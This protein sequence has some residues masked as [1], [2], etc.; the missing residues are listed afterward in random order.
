MT[1]RDICRACAERLCLSVISEHEDAGKSA[2]TTRGR[3]ALAAAMAVAIGSRAAIIVYRF[4]RL[5]RNLG[6]SYAIRDA[7]MAKG[8]RIIS[9][10][11]G[12]AESSPFSRAMFAMMATFAELENDI[13]RER[14][15]LGKTARAKQGG[16]AGGGSPVGFQNGRN[17][18]GIPILI[19]D[20]AMSEIIRAAF[21]DFIGGAI[22][23]A[24]MIQ[25]LCNAGIAKKTARRAILAPVYGGIIRNAWTGGQDIP[26]AFSGLIP[27]DQWRAMQSK[28]SRGKR[29]AL[30]DNP[31]FPF[32]RTIVCGICGHPC[33][34]GFSRCRNTVIGYYSCAT[35]GHITARRA[36]VHAQ[37]HALLAEF[38]QRLGRLSPDLAGSFRDPNPL[39]TR[40]DVPQIKELI[41]LVFIEFKLTREKKIEPAQNSIFATIV[42]EVR[43]DEIEKQIGR[44]ANIRP[45]RQ[46]ET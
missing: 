23:K 20:G 18:E 13:R 46:I 43:V 42:D 2:T 28:I 14:C 36:D 12:E 27:A 34:S 45:T 21:L 1:Q 24:Q 44:L 29:I 22:N 15:M 39:M 7:L 35:P 10:T 38:G 19:P 5:S 9:A 41:R 17:P 30:K 11:E 8:C 4:D 31:A 32:N 6:D 33:R 16:W 3:D 26:A 25:R 40:L 37:V